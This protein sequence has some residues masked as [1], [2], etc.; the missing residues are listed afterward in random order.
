MKSLADADRAIRELSNQS[1]APVSLQMLP[2]SPVQPA[3]DK[4]NRD[5]L[6]LAVYLLTARLSFWFPPHS[7][8]WQ[9]INPFCAVMFYGSSAQ[10]LESLYI[11]YAAG[12]AERL[13]FPLSGAGGAKPGVDEAKLFVGSLP[14]DVKEH[15]VILRP[16]IPPNEMNAVLTGFSFG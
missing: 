16:C 15:E 5:S 1:L 14:K 8:W 9:C 13:G 12:E 3:D 7:Y 10:P 6:K 4:L 2:A 11:R